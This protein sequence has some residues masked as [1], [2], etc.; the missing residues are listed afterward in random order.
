MDNQLTNPTWSHDIVCTLEAIRLNCVT[1]SEY[2][3]HNYYYY[4]SFLKYFRLPL[5]V[6][7][8][9]NSVA[10]V[11]LQG[12]LHQDDISMLTCGLALMTGIISSIELYMGIQ[13]SMETELFASRQFQILGYDIFKTL[14]IKEEHRI[15]NGKLFL[16]EKFNMYIKLVETAKIPRTSNITDRLAPLPQPPSRPHTPSSNPSIQSLFGLGATEP[17]QHQEV[18]LNQLN[19]L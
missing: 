11:G 16:E 1:L 3:K 8:S 6:I 15:E 10:S 5:I 17:Q 4:K 2:H 13:K 19:H 18:E 9:L 14:S 12:Y 7:S